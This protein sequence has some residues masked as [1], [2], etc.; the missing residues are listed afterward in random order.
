VSVTRLIG[1]FKRDG[2]VR[3]RGLQLA[4]CDRRRLARVAGGATEAR[5]AAEAGDATVAGAAVGGGVGRNLAGR[6][7][8]AT[9]AA[10]E[11]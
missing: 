11:R 6:V 10:R 2:L 1:E 9:A 4:D 5:A 7:G 3:E 8:Q